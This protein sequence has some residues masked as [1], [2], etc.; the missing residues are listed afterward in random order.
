MRKET[1]YCPVCSWECGEWI[2]ADHTDPGFAQG[3]GENFVD[4]AGVWYCSDDC[5][6]VAKEEEKEVA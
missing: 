5:L 2:P 6:I 4:D 3:I 1:I